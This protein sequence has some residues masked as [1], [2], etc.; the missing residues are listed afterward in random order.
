[1]DKSKDIFYY[2]DQDDCIQAAQLD[3]DERDEFLDMQHVIYSIPESDIGFNSIE[4]VRESESRY[5]MENHAQHL[6]RKL[7][8]LMNDMKMHKSVE[9]LADIDNAL[10]T[11]I[12]Y[13]NK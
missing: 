13:G 9:A 12:K 6:L 3:E 7:V 5:S 10:T 4:D 1:M 8:N 2:V 11:R